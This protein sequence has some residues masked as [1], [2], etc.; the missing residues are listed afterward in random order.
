MIINKENYELYAIDYIDGNLS[1]QEK[2]QMEQFLYKHPNIKK[3]LEGLGMVILTPNKKIVYDGKADLIQAERR[4]FIGW[5][6]LILLVLLI[7][8]SITLI[9]FQNQ[10]PLISD[11][12]T[13]VFKTKLNNLPENKQKIQNKII[14]NKP[15]IKEENK[16]EK[17]NVI[18]PTTPIQKVE[19]SIIEKTSV[20]ILPI[21]KINNTIIENTEDKKEDISTQ[22]T[23]NSKSL[24][25][26]LKHLSM[27]SITA[28]ELQNKDEYIVNDFVKTV[29]YQINRNVG[30]YNTKTSKIL[31]Y[32]MRYKRNIFYII[33]CFESSG[34]SVYS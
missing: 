28:K 29:E 9:W 17:N 10:N 6:G 18:K 13:T 27:A 20:P 12:T 16:I 33:C 2:G 30:F 5:G 7:S 26:Q 32:R 23:L 24:Y 25:I 34:I 19:P 1:D 22:N 11:S 31:L 3:E 8:T 21:V 14:P 4:P 15:S